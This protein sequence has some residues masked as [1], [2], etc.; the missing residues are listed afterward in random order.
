MDS[1]R[2]LNNEIEERIVSDLLKEQQI[3]SIL[4]IRK[5]ENVIKEQQNLKIM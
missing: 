5:Q 4:R 2:Q 3:D 1:K